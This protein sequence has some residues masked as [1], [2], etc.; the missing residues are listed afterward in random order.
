MSGKHMQA[1]LY[2]DDLYLCTLGQLCAYMS[3]RVNRCEQQKSTICDAC[4]P[5]QRNQSILKPVFRPFQWIHRAYVSLRC[6]DLEIWQFSCW[7]QQT[8]PIALPLAH[9]NK[10]S[11]LIPCKTSMHSATWECSAVYLICCNMLYA[12]S[13]LSDGSIGSFTTQVGHVCTWIAY[14]W[15][16]WTW[17]MSFKIIQQNVLW[18]SWKLIALYA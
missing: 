17:Q 13:C 11:I 3:R 9:A 16:K 2:V 14:R 18:F 6:L 5:C 8:K 12:F 4:G 7:R 15:S 1:T 10:G